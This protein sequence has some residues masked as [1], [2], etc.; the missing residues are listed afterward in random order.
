MNEKVGDDDNIGT[1]FVVCWQGIVA[2]LLLVIAL[3]ASFLAIDRIGVALAQGVFGGTAI[4]VSYIWGVVVF[5]EGV[6]DI[7]LSVV[8]IIL[9]IMGVIGIALNKTISSSF[10]H[11]NTSCSHD[12]NLLEHI[13]DEDTL[14]TRLSIS[15]PSPQKPSH[16]LSIG[17]GWA[18]TIL[19]RLRVALQSFLRSV[20]AR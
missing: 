15:A 10:P 20:S 7:A 11:Q 6:K 14:S 16:Q 17:I 18:V 3:G 13:T 9:L 4:L 2:G 8:G 1:K 12:D 5:Q 19:T